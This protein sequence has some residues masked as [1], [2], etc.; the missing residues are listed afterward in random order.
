MRS[1][2]GMPQ[3]HLGLLIGLVMVAILGCTPA[4][5]QAAVD[6][7]NVCDAVGDAPNVIVGDL[8]QIQRWGH[9]GDITA[10]SVGTFSCNIG[11]CWLNWI[12]GGDTNAH[13]TIGQ[14]MFRLKDGRFEQLGQSWLKHGFYALSETLCEPDCIATDG[15][16]LGVN[17]SDPYSSDLNGAQR[18]LGPKFEVRP[19]RG[20][21]PHP[22]TMQAVEGDEIFKRLQVH[23][24]DLDPALN[25]GARYFAEGQYVAE[26]D[27]VAGNHHDNASYRPIDVTAGGPRNFYDAALAGTTVRMKPAILAWQEADP[28]VQVIVL[29]DQAG[30]WFYLAARATDLG[31]GIWHYEYAVQNLDSDRAGRAF[32]VP[33]APGTTITNIA[34]HDVDYHS[35]EPY[36]GTDWAFG[37]TVDSL[38]WNTDDVATDPNANALRWGTLYNFRFDA[39]RPPAAAILGVDLFNPGQPGEPDTLLGASIGPDACNGNGSCDPGESCLSCPGECS[40]AGPDNDGDGLGFCVDCDANNGGLWGPVGEVPDLRRRRGGTGRVILYWQTPLER[41]SSAPPYEAL[42]SEIPSDFVTN[43]ACLRSAM[44]TSRSLTDADAETAG[45]RLYYLVRAR[46]ACVVEPG[47]TGGNSFGVVRS[48]ADCP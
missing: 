7:P 14:N 40:D 48:A 45:Q 13:P 10:F 12:T 26:D 2:I 41:G 28:S 25:V 18:R 47:T 8:H 1:W 43:A 35:G 6:D 34:F 29:D 39:D 38:R 30:G 44:R 36:V 24:A 15:E 5:A 42:R 23:D 20:F 27:A 21:H 11:T 22:V 16:H 19:S 17:C 4:A 32:S 3:R 46:S 31:G 9:I 33:V 37:G